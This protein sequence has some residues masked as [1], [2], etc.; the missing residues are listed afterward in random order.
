MGRLFSDLLRA[1]AD[2]WDKAAGPD[3]VDQHAAEAI[4]ILEDPETATLIQRTPEAIQ[5]YYQDKIAELMSTIIELRRALD[6]AHDDPDEVVAPSADVDEDTTIRL[7]L[8]LQEARRENAALRAQLAARPAPPF[9][10]LDAKL[11]EKNQDPDAQAVVD[12]ARAWAK[13]LGDYGH[14]LGAEGQAVINSVR[15]LDGEAP[16]PNRAAS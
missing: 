12:A 7:G 8:D 6:E 5:A 16:I 2:G 4:A 3:P 13:S 10:P 9:G 11:A 15:K 1:V 14:L